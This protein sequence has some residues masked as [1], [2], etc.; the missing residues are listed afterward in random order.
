MTDSLVIQENTR[1]GN[2]VTADIEVSK[3]ATLIIGGII[4]GQITIRKSATLIIDGIVNGNII[5]EGLCKIFGTI[6]GELIEN[7]GQFEIGKDA[8]INPK[9]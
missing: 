9:I 3:S 5:N 8:L 7:N 1:I 2:I 4:N 6:S